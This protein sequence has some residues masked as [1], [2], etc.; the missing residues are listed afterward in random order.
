MTPSNQELRHAIRGKTNEE[1]YDVLYTH[2][3][4]YTDDAI[5]LAREEF[6]LRKLD[7]PTV[8]NIRGAAYIQLKEEQVPLGWPLKLFAFFFATLLFGIP[9]LLMQRRF[10]E[11]GQKRKA[12]EFWSWALYGFGFYAALFI[13]RTILGILARQ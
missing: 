10:I 12:Q 13:A 5:E 4:D 8:S 2:P 11:Q 9:A 3:S 1:L 7:R 6:Q